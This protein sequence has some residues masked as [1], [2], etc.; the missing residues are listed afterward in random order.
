MCC[1]ILFQKEQQHQKEEQGQQE[2]QGQEQAAD[3]STEIAVVRQLIEDKL[4]QYDSLSDADKYLAK[5]MMWGW[6]ER[7]NNLGGNANDLL[8]RINAL[9]ATQ[10][11][12]NLEI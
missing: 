10:K 11:E 9:P 7:V 5:Q 12:K 4:A 8:A 3:V 1:Q 2:E 6:A